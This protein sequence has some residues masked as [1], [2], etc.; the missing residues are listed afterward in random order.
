[1]DL[2]Q[3]A[4]IIRRWGWLGAI[5]VIVVGLMLAVS[6]QPPSGT[7]QVTMRFT[8]GSVPADPLSPDYDRYYAWLSSE[9]IANGLADFAMTS[10][11]ARGVAD[12]LEEAGIP[13]APEAIQSAIV[14]DNAQ[15]ML[16]VRLTW[17]DADQSVA[18]AEAV[19]AELLEAGPVFYPQMQ[20]VG[21]VAQQVDVPHPVRVAPG[22]RSQLMGSALRLA[23]AFVTGAGLIL[24]AHYIDPWLREPTELTEQG[25]DIVGAIPRTSARQSVKHPGQF[26]TD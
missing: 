11:F 17:P 3:L 7:Y 9:Y 13:V 4:K 16:E 20:G 26:R 23:L 15:S 22:L 2:Q 21:F 8:A 25:L 6:Y 14:T 5:P 10:Y 24:A 18:V 19:S 12:R 1:M